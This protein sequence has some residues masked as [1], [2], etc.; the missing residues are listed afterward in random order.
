MFEIFFIQLCCYNASA[1]LNIIKWRF[2]QTIT[3]YFLKHHLHQYS[4][5]PHDFSTIFKRISGA[6]EWCWN[7]ESPKNTHIDCELKIILLPFD[8]KLSQRRWTSIKSQD[9]NSS[10]NIYWMST[11][12]TVVNLLPLYSTFEGLFNDAKITKMVLVQ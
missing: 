1:I 11:N 4:S 2:H 7:H 3:K 12:P 10:S 9:S 8:E 5:G 6:F